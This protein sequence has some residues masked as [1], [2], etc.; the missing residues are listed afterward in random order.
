MIDIETQVFNKI[1]TRIRAEYDPVTVYGEYVRA[2]SVFPSVMV[3]ESDNYPLERTQTSDN[4]ENHVVLVYEINVYSN[5]QAGKKTQCKDIFKLV[6]EEMS[7]M[8]FT[9]TSLNPIPNLDKEIKE[10]AF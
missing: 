8:G 4:V 10:P 1:A 9:R 2:P 5:K 6:D 7:K 3:T